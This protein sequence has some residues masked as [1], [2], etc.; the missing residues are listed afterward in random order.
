MDT[1]SIDVLIIPIPE[2]NL[3]KEVTI[4]FDPDVDTGENI[5]QMIM[6]DVSL[7][8]SECNRKNNTFWVIDITDHSFRLMFNVEAELLESNPPSNSSILLE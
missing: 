1:V 5:R 4:T 3:C 6:E 8:R 2:H 7:L